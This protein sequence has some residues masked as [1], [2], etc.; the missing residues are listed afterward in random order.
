MC[1]IG[2]G[3]PIVL[4]THVFTYVIMLSQGSQIPSLCDSPLNY[5]DHNLLSR[6][7]QGVGMNKSNPVL[8]HKEFGDAPRQYRMLGWMYGIRL[9]TWP[10]AAQTSHKH[11]VPHLFSH[12]MNVCLSICLSIS[13]ISCLYMCMYKPTNTNKCRCE[14]THKRLSTHPCAHTYQTIHKLILNI[15]IDGQKVGQTD[16]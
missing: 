13:C 8:W 9:F 10:K 12:S 3:K 6:T 4:H 16:S 2:G 14:N 7:W 11:V 5:D 15:N 1:Y